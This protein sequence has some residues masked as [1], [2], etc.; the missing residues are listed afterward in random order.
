MKIFLITIEWWKSKDGRNKTMYMGNSYSYAENY[1][2]IKHGENNLNYIPTTGNVREIH[3]EYLDEDI[4]I[5]KI[6]K[7]SFYNYKT[8]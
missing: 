6:K 3:V 4:A 1:F 7:L 8:D 5:E 2:I